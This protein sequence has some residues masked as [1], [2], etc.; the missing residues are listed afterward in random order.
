MPVFT[1]NTEDSSAYGACLIAAV[2]TGI[3]PTVE[4]ACQEWVKKENEIIPNPEEVEVYE[5]IYQLY[6]R[7][8][9][10]LKEDFHTLSRYSIGSG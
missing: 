5:K 2:G 8:Y 1:A 4:E 3:F 9:P 6:R 10:K 7:L